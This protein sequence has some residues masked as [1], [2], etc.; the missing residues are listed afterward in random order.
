[1]ELDIPEGIRLHDLHWRGHGWGAVVSCAPGHWPSRYRENFRHLM[2]PG[3]NLYHE[4]SAGS[5]GCIS[6]QQAIDAACER[7]I[8]GMRQLDGI[9]PPAEPDVEETRERRRA[10]RAARKARRLA[11]EGTAPA[12]AQDAQASAAG[13]AAGS[14]A[15]SA[16]KQGELGL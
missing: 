8:A 10:R 4:Q 15:A 6:A 12:A 13:V 7:L 16:G 11:A 2:P 3:T 14:R 5:D 1:M 9:E